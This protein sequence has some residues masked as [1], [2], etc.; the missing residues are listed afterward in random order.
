MPCFS[1]GRLRGVHHHTPRSVTTHGQSSLSAQTVV[2]AQFLC[3]NQALHIHQLLH[4]FVQAC[5]PQCVWQESRRTGLLPLHNSSGLTKA[6]LFPVVI[7][8]CC[9]F[10][11][12]GVLCFL[13]A[14]SLQFVLVVACKHSA[15]DQQLWVAVRCVTQAPVVVCTLMHAWLCA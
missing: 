5:P 4:T 10:L 13:R 2:F 8:S 3:F 14:V 7:G 15:A 12:I 11:F 6:G 9:V 1:S